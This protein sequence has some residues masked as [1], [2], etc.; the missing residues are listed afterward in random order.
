MRIVIAGATGNLGVLVS[1]FLSNFSHELVLLLHRRSLP[2]DLSSKQN[3]YVKKIDLNDPLS[4]RGCCESADTV[5]SMAGVLFRGAPEKFLPITNT[6]H[7][8]NLVNEAVYAGVKKFVLLSFPHVEGETS[9]QRPAKGVLPELDPEPIHAK[10]RLEAERYLVRTCDSTGLRYLILRAGV[11]YGRDVKLIE[12]ARRYL[13]LRALAVWR[14]PIW[15]HLL[16]LPDF[17]DLTRLSIEDSSMHGILNIA[18]DAPLLLQDFMDQLAEHWGYSHPIRLPERFF[19]SAAYALDLV[20][21]LFHC[22]IPLNP[23]ILRMA[24]TS[25]VADTSRLRMELGY[26]LRYPTLADGLVLC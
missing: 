10:T 11:I 17:L 24:L 9:P 6:R 3:V 8:A 15:V 14:K 25:A 18:D 7:V 26:R 2:Q 12:A 19:T 16:T 22:A 23:D 21:R 20:S 13:R 5:V 4:L 1:R